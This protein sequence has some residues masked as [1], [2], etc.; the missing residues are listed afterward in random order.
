MSNIFMNLELFLGR[1]YFKVATG[2]CHLPG[3]PIFPG[4]VGPPLSLDFIPGLE[5]VI[6]FPDIF[7]PLPLAAHQFFYITDNMF[8]NKLSVLAPLSLKV[9]KPKVAFSGFHIL[10]LIRVTFLQ[11]DICWLPQRS[12]LPP[13]F[14]SYLALP[15][16]VVTGS[17]LR[18][19]SLRA[20][21]ITSK[22][23]SPV[24]YVPLLLGMT[25]ECNQDRDS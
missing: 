9:C 8:N 22:T 4:F 11:G 15:L 7:L 24:G 16:S 1:N 13:G 19:S 6:V 17:L 21:T 14:D 20:P 5:A 2:V 3:V 10:L 18:C 12:F 25:P 23:F